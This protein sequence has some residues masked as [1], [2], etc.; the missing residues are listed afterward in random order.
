MR[1]DNFL[2][3]LAAVCGL[4]TAAPV[5]AGIIDIDAS[6]SGP[7]NTIQN[8]GS[9]G[10]SFG[11]TDGGFSLIVWSA[12]DLGRID[13]FGPTTDVKNAS[14]TVQSWAPVSKA[15]LGTVDSTVTFLS[16][17]TEN[18]TTSGSSVTVKAGERLADPNVEAATAPEPWTWVMIGLGGVAVGMLRLIKPR[19]KQPR[20]II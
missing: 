16:G 13:L 1:T 14:G 9:P 12:I 17:S 11:M 4:L 3:P 8:A 10:P 18:D 20:Y 7:T 6:A 2:C 5:A 19:R 15:G